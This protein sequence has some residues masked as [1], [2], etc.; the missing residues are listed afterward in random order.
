MEIV[1]VT[2]V[3]DAIIAALPRTKF[4]DSKPSED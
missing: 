3:L 2:K 4:E 1:T